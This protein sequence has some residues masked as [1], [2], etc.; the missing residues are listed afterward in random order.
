MT[1]TI[2]IL[3]IAGGGTY[4]DPVWLAAFR[5]TEDGRGHATLTDRP[6]RA[7]RF[8]RASDALDFWRQRS[9]YVPFRP[10]G[11]PNRPLT[12]YHIEI[13]RLEH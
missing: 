13:R 12:A 4:V 9:R 1:V 6:E 8:P 5:D 2:R 3:G 11:K 10:D 7:L